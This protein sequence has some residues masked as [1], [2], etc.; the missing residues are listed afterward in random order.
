MSTS[1]VELGTKKIE[2]N[3][4]CENY[5]KTHFH[6]CDEENIPFKE[7]TFDL[8]LSSMN[9]HWINDLPSSLIQV[10]MYININYILLLLFIIKLIICFI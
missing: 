9:M 2:Y 4:T 10:S 6:V 3:P 7:E 8:V 1:P 5:V